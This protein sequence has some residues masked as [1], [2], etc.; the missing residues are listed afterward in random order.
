[1]QCEL[2]KLSPVEWNE[3]LHGFDDA[4]I[5]QTV[6][7]PAA[8]W[9]HER[10]H[11]LVVTEN[12]VIVAAAQVRIIHPPM[13]HC[14]LA[15]IS[16]GPLWKK[17]NAI[18]TYP[19]F[20]RILTAIQ[21]FVTK[22]LK[23]FLLIKPNIYY[24]SGDDKIDFTS[25]GFFSDTLAG[26]LSLLIDI[27][28]DL[29]V[30]LASMHQKW[31]NA[32]N[33]ALKSDFVIKSGTDVKYF[34]DFLALNREMEERKMFTERMDLFA[35]KDAQHVENEGNKLQF[36]VAYHDDI[37]VAAA[38]VSFI[39]DTA[40]YLLGASD[41]TGRKLNASYAIQWQVI[42]WLKNSGAHWYDLGGIVLREN[43]DGPLLFKQRLAG[44][45]GKVIEFA[46]LLSARG[47]LLSTLFTKSLLLYSKIRR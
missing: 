39:G 43:P 47:S 14:G 7:Y 9:G 5:Y 18:V 33:K 1:M 16:A 31:R 46:P 12:D 4:N 25:C 23:Y 8:R 27:S 32:L 44:K 41:L 2:K 29:D 38:A 3:I 42:N 34:D 21:L 37:P 36:F 20:V 17:R 28:Q 30:I 19:D 35:L 13:L 40:V 15:Y 24:F 26:S 6:G 22:K 11:H 10:I 45:N